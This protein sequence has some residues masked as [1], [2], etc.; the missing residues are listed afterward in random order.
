MKRSRYIFEHFGFDVI[1]LPTDFKRDY[2]YAFMWQDLLPSLGGLEQNYIISHEIFGILS[3]WPQG[4]W[5][6]FKS[7][8]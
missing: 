1:E 4:I 8:T 6:P 7:T 2:P 5:S 3:L